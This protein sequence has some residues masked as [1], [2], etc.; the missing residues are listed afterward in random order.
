MKKEKIL[1]LNCINCINIKQATREMN[2][3]LRNTYL[4]DVE[5]RKN[6]LELGGKELCDGNRVFNI[7]DDVNS[8]PFC[9]CFKDTNIRVA[10][11]RN[12]L[13][14]SLEN[15]VETRCREFPYHVFFYNGRKILD[16]TF[17]QFLIG[18]NLSALRI[19]KTYPEFFINNVF[20]GTPK[21]AMSLG[22]IYK[23]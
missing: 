23:F 7:Y 1:S 21:N 15:P 12:K 5:L 14:V 2:E 13:F 17:G 18:Q 19:R 16:P 10:N 6:L 4:K 11:Q 22:V 9:D 20:V 8:N 3:M